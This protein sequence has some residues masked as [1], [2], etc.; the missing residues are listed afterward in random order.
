MT[1]LAVIP[2]RYASSRLPGKPLV[3]IVG[4]PMIQHVYDRVRTARSVD[5]V[6]VA[7]DDARIVA[8]VEGFGGRAIMTSPHHA[9]GTSRTAEAVEGERAELVIN[10]QGD[11]PLIAPAMIDELVGVMKADDE[12][13]FATLCYEIPPEQYDNP[14]VVKVVRDTGDYA[15]YFSRSPIP[16][17]RPGSDRH[18]YEHIGIYGYTR[19]FLE[20]YARLSETPLAQAESLE[21]LRALE[22]GHRIK[23]VETR[24]PY[25]ALSVDDEDDLARVRR[26]VTDSGT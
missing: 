12:P 6:I 23:V 25:D 15:L 13:E 17:G 5:D 8:A 10:V 1:V 21:Q 3:D 4:K 9:N 26:I 18:L 19:G 22:H 20:T 16:F 24:V 7:T 14:N 11:E 2:A